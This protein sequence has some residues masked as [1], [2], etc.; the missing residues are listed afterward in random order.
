M[1]K[2]AIKVGNGSAE[3][4]ELLR[5][6]TLEVRA[7]N[8]CLDDFLQ[9]RAKALG[10]TGPQLAI[11]MAV[12]DLDRDSGVPVSA[13]AKLMKVDPSFITTHSKAL[14]KAGLMRRRPCVTDARVVQMSL[15]DKACKRL[16]NVATQQEELDHFVFGE[17]GVEKMTTLPSRLAAL[18]KRL[19]RARL[20]AA[21]DL[22]A[23]T[24]RGRARV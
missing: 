20:K 23:A 8:V 5:R 1:P 24:L 10:I 22:G 4:Q 7:L 6:L 2:Q 17:L 19:E 14:E 3:I 9:V 16:A 15:T 13:V 12:T 18:R 11:L 21:V